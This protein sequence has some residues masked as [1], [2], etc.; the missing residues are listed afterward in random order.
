M[1]R[2]GPNPSS[3]P[4]SSVT[5]R[6]H[7][8]KDEQTSGYYH[9]FRGTNVQVFNNSTVMFLK[10]LEQINGKYSFIFNEF[11]LLFSNR[12]SSNNWSN[13]CLYPQSLR[14]KIHQSERKDF[15]QVRIK[16]PQHSSMSIIILLVL[17]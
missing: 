15:K 10:D 1:N 5:L 8:L 2:L 7:Y 14:T 13:D 11:I 6:I 9:Q 12:L 17:I 16:H 4:G 3:P